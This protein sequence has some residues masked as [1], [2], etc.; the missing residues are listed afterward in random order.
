MIMMRQRGTTLIELIIGIAIVAIL[1]AMAA[2]GF[3]LWMQNTQNRGAAESILNGMQLARNEAVK[4]NTKVRF[5]LT[6]AS[7]DGTVA[8]K[9]GCVTVTATCPDSIQSRDANQGAVN[10]RVGVDTTAISLPTPTTQFNTA[11]AAGTNLPAGVS[12][13]GMGRVVNIGDDITRIDVTNVV[14]SS[15]RRY[16]VIVWTGGMIRMCDPAL[17]FSSNSQGCS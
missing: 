14:V 6:D 17:V 10:A 13:D 8:W 11:I 1:M 9:V 2:P 5:D 3:R 12:F 16:V 7:G 15:A 4:R